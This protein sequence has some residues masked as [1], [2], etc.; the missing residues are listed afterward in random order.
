MLSTRDSAVL[1]A[2]FN[3]RG[4]YA[5]IQFTESDLNQNEQMQLEQLEK[6]GVAAAE[7]GNYKQ[8]IEIFSKL[9]E[10]HPSYASA[11]NNRAQVYR[12]LEKE[13]LALKD[14]DNCI[15]LEPASFI[16]RQAYTQ[17]SL[18]YKKMG[19]LK[20]SDESLL[21]AAQHGSIEAKVI[22]RDKDV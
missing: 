4:E 21:K 13:D 9:I 22:V 14:L 2:I 8:S 1:D 15:S 17:R 3:S 19:D 11:F 12:L 7:N 20:K 5:G 18:I 6:D 16:L 10:K